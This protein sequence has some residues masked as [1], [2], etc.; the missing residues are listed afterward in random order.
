MRERSSDGSFPW[1]DRYQSQN[2]RGE[3]CFRTD[4]RTRPTRLNSQTDPHERPRLF[5]L[6][7]FRKAFTAISFLH[8]LHG[9]PSRSTGRGQP[10]RTAAC[11]S[12]RLN[13]PIGD[14]LVETN[15][16]SKW[17]SDLHDP[18]VPWSGF[19]ARIHVGAWAR[20]DLSMQCLDVVGMNE[21]LR[22]RRTVS[23]VLGKM[24]HHSP[25]GDL[26]IARRIRRKS[27]LPINSKAEPL[28]VEIP[29]QLI[30]ED[31]EERDRCL[32]RHRFCA[33]GKVRGRCPTIPSIVFLFKF[34]S[35]LPPP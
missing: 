9:R 11:S 6:A 24:K 17:I 13:A 22:T 3:S 18:G 21:E 34:S 8:A 27:M 19:D 1:C 31:S 10:F 16:V 4:A 2:Q 25:P 15:P 33:I 32:E 35:S 28:H 12:P 23:V 20:R 14:A 26:D 30:V 7:R 29:R 5:R